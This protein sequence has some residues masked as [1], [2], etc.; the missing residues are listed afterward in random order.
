VL[1]GSVLPDAIVMQPSGDCHTF[2]V[3]MRPEDE[4]DM[5]WEAL[6]I[7]SE[8]TFVWAKDVPFRLILF[9]LSQSAA[10]MSESGPGQ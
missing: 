3:F 4:T 8:G 5:G 2:Y 6:D 10:G 9:F 7:V 1:T